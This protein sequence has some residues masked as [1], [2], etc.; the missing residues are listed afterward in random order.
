MSEACL[1]CGEV[2]TPADARPIRTQ[3][4]RVLPYFGG[5]DT[6]L[7]YAIQPADR[8]KHR[9]VFFPHRNSTT[10]SAPGVAIDVAIHPACA[11]RLRPDHPLYVTNVEALS[12]N[13]RIQQLKNEDNRAHE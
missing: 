13:R 4:V 2:N 8:V 1:I 10:H 7:V 11:T 3:S 9:S 12:I 5:D 6:C